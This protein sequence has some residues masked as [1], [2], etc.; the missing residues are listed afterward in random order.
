MKIKKRLQITILHKIQHFLQGLV[1]DFGKRG[2]TSK[3]KAL[4]L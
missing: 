2:G 3:F 4:E 1:L